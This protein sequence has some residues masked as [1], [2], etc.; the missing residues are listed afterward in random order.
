MALSNRSN[1]IAQIIESIFNDSHSCEEENRRSPRLNPE[2]ANKIV[3]EN[4]D[5][6]SKELINISRDIIVGH[7]SIPKSHVRITLQPDTNAR[8]MANFF[9]VEM[10]SPSIELKQPRRTLTF[11]E[12]MVRSYKRS[13]RIIDPSHYKMMYSY[14]KIKNQINRCYLCGEPIE[15]NSRNDKIHIEHKIPS[16]ILTILSK[17]LLTNPIN[18][19]TVDNYLQ[20]NTNNNC[21]NKNLLHLLFAYTHSKCNLNKGNSLFVCFRLENNHLRCMTNKLNI[22]KY[23]QT[24]NGS[25]SRIVWLESHFNQISEAINKAKIHKTALIQ[26][27]R[28]IDNRKPF[29]VNDVIIE[30]LNTNE[31]ELKMGGD[32]ETRKQTYHKTKQ[33]KKRKS[34]KVD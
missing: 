30:Q 7:S 28:E 29:I 1:R 24:I 19:L 11:N 32:V 16:D 13:T 3:K 10:D 23:V 8:Q 18:L 22:T 34:I 5:I 9:G 17:H 26:N 4:E 33:T 12:Y 27:L 25:I 2:L 15:Y 14:G 20:I 21:R 6:A 31:P